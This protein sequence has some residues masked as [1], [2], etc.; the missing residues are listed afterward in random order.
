MSE[1]PSDQPYEK[2]FESEGKNMITSLQYDAQNEKLWYGT[3]QSS[4]GCLDMKD[5]RGTKHL[6]VTGKL[7]L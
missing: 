4:F 6:E 7:S 2:V 1:Q 3:P 5:K